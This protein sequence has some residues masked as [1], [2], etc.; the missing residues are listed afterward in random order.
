MFA[1]IEAHLAKIGSKPWSED[2]L[3]K[4][5]KYLKKGYSKKIVEIKRL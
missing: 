2:G 3:M 1:A 4:S 5:L